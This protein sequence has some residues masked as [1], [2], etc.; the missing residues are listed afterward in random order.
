MTL[1]AI[2][3]W[4]VIL[5]LVF[6]IFQTSFWLH[7]RNVAH[8]AATTAYYEAR[9]VNGTAAN[10][11]AAATDAITA[12]G[13]AIDSPAITVNRTPVTVTVTVTGRTSLIIPGWPG[14]A[15]SETVTGPVE[16]YIAP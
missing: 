9:T 15:L 4:P 3:I 2:I 7:A 12:S 1:E 5:T 14:S 16:R 6:G 10:A 11:Q 13:G 8:G